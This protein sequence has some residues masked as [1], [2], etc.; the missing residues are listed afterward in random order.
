MNKIFRQGKHKYI[1]KYIN[2]WSSASHVFVLV[3][4]FLLTGYAGTTLFPQF[5]DTLKMHW[6]PLNKLVSSRS[7]VIRHYL[8]KT[9]AFNIFTMINR[10]S[11]LKSFPSVSLACLER[12][13]KILKR[14]DTFRAPAYKLISLNR[15]KTK[16][17]KNSRNWINTL[18]SS[19][20][21]TY[22]YLRFLS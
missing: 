20:N 15:E 16:R 19:L 6:F 12:P 2:C 7:D 9:I 4:L 11:T 14:H 10:F 5:F 1:S 18:I 13:P 8:Y 3:K 22:K 21:R 17:K